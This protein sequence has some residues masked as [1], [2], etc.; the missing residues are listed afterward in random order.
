VQQRVAPPLARR[1][2]IE[3]P[4]ALIGRVQDRPQHR[5]LGQP[6]FLGSL[7]VRSCRRRQQRRHARRSA[8]I[9]LTFEDRRRL[10]RHA[11]SERPGQQQPLHR[12]DAIVVNHSV[13]LSHYGRPAFC[14]HDAEGQ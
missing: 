2:V 6:C 4:E 13:L 11:Q 5:A 3:K 12:Q 7:A 9:R 1:P 10:L 14:A 8:G